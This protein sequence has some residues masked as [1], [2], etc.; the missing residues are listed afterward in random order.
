MAQSESGQICVRSFEDRNANGLLDAGEPFLTNGVSAILRD[1]ER[2]AIQTLSLSDS[3]T[4]S[5]G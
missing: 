4:A 5:R 3:P 1:E 2:T